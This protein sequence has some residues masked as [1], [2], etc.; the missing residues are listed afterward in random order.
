LADAQRIGRVWQ[1]QIHDDSSI[2]QGD[3]FR[4]CEYGNRKRGIIR[5]QVSS[6]FGEKTMKM[7]LFL[8]VAVLAVLFTASFVFAADTVCTNP[9]GATTKI[10]VA[11][12][13]FGPAQTMAANFQT[14]NP[15]QVVNVCHNSTGVL[16]QEILDAINA[17]PPV[18]PPYDNLFAA[19]AIAPSFLTAINGKLDGSYTPFL[20]ANGLPVLFGYHAGV[21]GKTFNVADVSQL[22]NGLSDEDQEASLPSPLNGYSIAT[23]TANTVA[24]ADPV[25]APY[26]TQA[27]AILY[28]LASHSPAVVTAQFDNIGLTY[29]VVGTNVTVNGVSYDIHSGFVSKAQIC[30][31]IDDENV[32]YVE[33][34]GYVLTQRAI[35]LTANGTALKTYIQ[36]RIDDTTWDDFLTANCYQGVN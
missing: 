22:I 11:S 6:M 26:G 18:A 33:F 12:N 8:C 28:D 19:D 21:T 1:R 24:V 30:Q 10:A 23:S 31:D 27:A 29:G 36:N 3:D 17:T 9:P 13:F 16:E 14:A 5:L 32:A 7:R 25:N 4:V 20:Y 15:G 35:Q 34:P 2:G